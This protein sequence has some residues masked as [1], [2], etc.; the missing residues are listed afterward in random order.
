MIFSKTL[1]TFVMATAGVLLGSSL[2]FANIHVRITAET[3]L[4]VN[5]INASS[6]NMFCGD[7]KNEDFSLSPRQIM[8]CSFTHTHGLTAVYFRI[9]TKDGVKCPILVHKTALT[10]GNVGRDPDHY[11]PSFSCDGVH[12]EGTNIIVD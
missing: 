4:D 12:F 3:A 2:A 11:L 7:K 1:Q 6:G 10:D 8:K 5:H 9:Y